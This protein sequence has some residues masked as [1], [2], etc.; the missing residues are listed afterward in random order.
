MVIEFDKDTPYEIIPQKDRFKIIVEFDKL[1]PSPTHAAYWVSDPIVKEVSFID[2][3]AKIKTEITLKKGGVVKKTFS[4]KCT[5][6]Y[7]FGYHP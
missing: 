6:A 7:C 5:S 3:P 1:A 2:T 4:L